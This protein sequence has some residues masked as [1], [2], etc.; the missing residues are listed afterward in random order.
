MHDL[1]SVT[2]MTF[3][4]DPLLF[5][6]SDQLLSDHILKLLLTHLVEVHLLDLLPRKTTEPSPSLGPTP[7]FLR[8]TC[9]L[10]AE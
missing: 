5:I 2:S 8:E 6:M 9:R 3:C 4:L 10:A 7:E 1:T